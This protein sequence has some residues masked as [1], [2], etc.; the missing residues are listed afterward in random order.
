VTDDDL[1]YSASNISQAR[2]HREVS[3]P[4]TKSV[5][6]D[7]QASEDL[8]EEEL[9]VMTPVESDEDDEL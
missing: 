4:G 9:V 2:A 5:I 7:S 6:E 3:P 1:S 8:S